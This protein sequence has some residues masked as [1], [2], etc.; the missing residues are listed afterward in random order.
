MPPTVLIVV[1]TFQG[2]EHVGKLAT[3][4]KNTPYPVRLVD[5]TEGGRDVGALLRCY[6]ENPNFDYYFLMHD[7]MVVKRPDFINDFFKL[8]GDVNCWLKFPMFY[9]YPNQK[10]YIE[11][12]LGSSEAEFGIFGPIMLIP[13]KVITRVIDEGFYPPIPRDKNEQCGWERGWAVLFE[14]MGLKVEFIDTLRGQE[15]LDNDEYEHFKK[16]CPHRL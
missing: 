7:S 11:A 16:N 9:D 13:R 10:A 2:D 4:L 6:K 14:L 3:S 5:T 12:I 8:G 1:P 15:A